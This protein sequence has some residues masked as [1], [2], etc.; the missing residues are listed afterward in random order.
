MNEWLV[1]VTEEAGRRKAEMH[2]PL[3]PVSKNKKKGFLQLET[4]LSRARGTSSATEYIA[5]LGTQLRDLFYENSYQGSSHL[6]IQTFQGAKHTHDLRATGKRR[7]K[8][9]NYS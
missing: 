8:S 3:P 5:Y 6:F 2:P 1:V 4:I 9:G 7:G